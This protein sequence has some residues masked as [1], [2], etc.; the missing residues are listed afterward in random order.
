M[1]NVL[2]DMRDLP[3]LNPLGTPVLGMPDDPAG[4]GMKVHY[5][6]HNL[7]GQLMLRNQHTFA[8]KDGF[9]SGCVPKKLHT[10]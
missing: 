4:S 5:R 8:V 3:R 10:A 1:A 9:V 2:H 6:K 7:I